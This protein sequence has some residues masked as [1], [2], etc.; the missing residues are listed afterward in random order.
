MSSCFCTARSRPAE[1]GWAASATSDWKGGRRAHGA[2]CGAPCAR[3]SVRGWGTPLRLKRPEVAPAPPSTAMK[4]SGQA[5]S[6]S[7]PPL[8]CSVINVDAGRQS[9]D[10][11]RLFAS[12]LHRFGTVPPGRIFR[13]D[14]AGLVD[15]LRHAADH[16]PDAVVVCGGDGTARTAIE[17]LTPLGI[18]TAPLPGGTLNRLA[19]AVY[20]SI[21]VRGIA[22]GLA[23]GAPGWIPAGSI[24]GNRFFVVSGYGE[25]MKLNSVREALRRRSW[26][27]AWRGVRCMSGKMLRDLIEVGAQG[28]RAHLAVVALGAVDSAFGLRPG[29]ER[30][31]LE[32]AAADVTS[33]RSALS[34]SGAA[35]AGEWRRCTSV[36]AGRTFSLTLKGREHGIPALLDGEP[37]LLPREGTITFEERGGLVWRMAPSR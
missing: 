35:L 9:K 29:A 16:R 30:N 20:G 33:W 19:H 1:I 36:T 24:A 26:W 32:Y 28:K 37:I 4:P 22:T 6:S 34:I 15:A 21:N 12:L 14:S 11:G 23:R 3:R 13:T 31:F 27:E 18:P 10:G 5:L 2:A 8:L 7:S 17:I 25:P